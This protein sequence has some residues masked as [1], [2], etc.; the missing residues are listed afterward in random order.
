MLSRRNIARANETAAINRQL[1]APKVRASTQ[2][3]KFVI[4]LHRVPT[5]YPGASLRVLDP[6]PAGALIKK[7]RFLAGVFDTGASLRGVFDEAIY[8]TLTDLLR[9][10]SSAVRHK[11]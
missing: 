5:P 4:L 7:P 1:V 9:A 6:P 8:S 11:H 10:Q 3:Q 2:L